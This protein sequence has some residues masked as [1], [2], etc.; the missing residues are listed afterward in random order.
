[1]MKFLKPLL[2][3]LGLAAL[4][5]ASASV[6]PDWIETQNFNG[7][8]ATV[9]TSNLADVVFDPSG[10]IIGW[11]IKLNAGTRLIDEKDGQPNFIKLTG[12]QGTVNLVRGGSAL[13]VDIAGNTAARTPRPVQLVRDVAGNRMQAIFTYSQGAATVTKTV[14][15]H[16]RQFNM[17][18]EINVMGASGYTVAFD[19][20][21]KNAAP[22]IRNL[23]QG[24]QVVE[25][26]ATTKNVQ[27][28]ALY[29]T[30]TTGFLGLGS[31]SY[32]ANMMVVRPGTGTTLSATTVGGQKAGLILNAAG[33]TSS[34]STAART[35]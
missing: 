35:S 25:G 4:G 10:E 19:G 30:L 26:A 21:G 1:M 16:P 6:K 11:Y 2:A 28:A 32:T 18:T 8:P 23:G 20:L 7:K 17:Q 12:E 5:S 22:A 29:D 34:T 33:R 24:G 31:N 9:Y 3:A 15:L 27:Y 13:R 14:V